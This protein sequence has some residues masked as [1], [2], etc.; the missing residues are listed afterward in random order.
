MNKISATVDVIERMDVVSYIY[1][2]SGDTV[3]RLIKSEIPGWLEIGDKITCTFREAS[4]S[5]SKECPGKISIENALPATLKEVRENASLCELT[6][7]SDVGSVVSLITSSAYENLGLEPGCR[8]TM[9]LRG[10]DINIEP[11]LPS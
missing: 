10:I 11:A 5:I 8:A 1:V 4:V 2:N 3:I 7:E 6:L 9:L